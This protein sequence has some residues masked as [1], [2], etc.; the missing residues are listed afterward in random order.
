MQYVALP[1]FAL[2]VALRLM[3]RGDIVWKV[4]DETPYEDVLYATVQCNLFEDEDTA[5]KP[6]FAGWFGTP[7]HEARSRLPEMRP[8]EQIGAACA[9]SAKHRLPK[10]GFSV[11]S[12]V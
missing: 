8:L 2:E 4:A 12:L 9:D 1:F 5:C 7:E 11:R 6:P 10:E 3:G